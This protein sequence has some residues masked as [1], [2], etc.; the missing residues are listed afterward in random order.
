MKKSLNIIFS[1]LICFLFFSCDNLGLNYFAF[2]NGTDGN[3]NSNFSPENNNGMQ[4]VTINIVNSTGSEKAVGWPD[5]ESLKSTI[6]VYSLIATANGMPT[7][8]VDVNGANPVC[9]LFLN[10]DIEWTIGVNA[11]DDESKG[12][13]HLVMTGVQNFTPT[14]SNSSVTITVKPYQDKTTGGG[15]TG[16]I[17]LKIN[18]PA[19]TD[20]Y[21][22]NWYVGENHGN[23]ISVSSSGGD[24]NFSL[25]GITPGTN[26][27][28]M[29]ITDNATNRV[30]KKIFSVVIYSNVTSS[31]WIESGIAKDQIS[32]DAEDLRSILDGD[33]CFYVSG[34]G[35]SLG[36]ESNASS[37][38][39][40]NAYKFTTVQKAVNFIENIDQ[41]GNSEHTIYI[42]GVVSLVNGEETDGSMVC[43]GSTVSGSEKSPKITLK[44]YHNDNETDILNADGLAR[45]IKVNNTKVLLIKNIG[46]MNGICSETGA[47]VYCG[48]G[49]VDFENTCVSLCQSSNA[50]GAGGIFVSENSTVSF[51]GCTVSANIGLGYS[52][53][54]LKGKATLNGTNTIGYMNEPS[55]E[56]GIF[57]DVTNDSN[58]GKIFLDSTALPGSNGKICKIEITGSGEIS[59]QKIINAASG[60]NLTDTMCSWFEVAEPYYIDTGDNIGE[61]K[62]LGPDHSYFVNSSHTGSEIGTHTSPF[63][64]VQNAVNDIVLKNDGEEYTIYVMD[65]ISGSSGA[66]YGSNG[67]ALVNIDNSTGSNKLKLKICSDVSGAQRTISVDR[68]APVNENTMARVISVKGAVG[69]E[70]ELT[71]EDIKILNG[72]L[73][74]NNYGA[75]ILIS[76]YSTVTLGSNFEESANVSIKGSGIYCAGGIS[77]KLVIAD[78]YITVS[79]EIY[80]SD[81]SLI[82]QKTGGG[83]LSNK[84]NIDAEETGTLLGRQVLS[85]VDAT[86]NFN[87]FSKYVLLTKTYCIDSSGKITEA[88]TVTNCGGSLPSARKLTLS[89]K[90]ELN[91]I[92]TWA[93]NNTLANF[94]FVMTGDIDLEGSDTDQ[95]T[96]IGRNINYPFAGIFDGNGHTITGLYINSTSDYQGLFGYCKNIIKNICVKGEVKGANYAG[97]ICGY[98]DTIRINEPGVIEN[99][100]SYVD[101]SGSENVGGICGKVNFS[102][103]KNC[104]NLGKITG[105]GENTGG[106]S[107]YG[108]KSQISNCANLGEV[109]GEGTLGGI[110]GGGSQTSTIDYCYNAGPVTG[111]CISGIT[112]ATISN[113]YYL[114]GCGAGQT[115]ATS[116]P[117]PADIKTALDS[118]PYN[119]WD[120]SYVSGGNTYPVCVEIPASFMGTSVASCGDT[121]PSSGTYFL[122]TPAE[123]KKISEWTNSV[124]LSGCTF[125]MTQDIDLEG[126]VTNA[127]TPIGSSN[128]FSGTFDGKGYTVKGLYINSPDSNYQGLF[129]QVKSANIKNL[130]V[131]GEVTGQNNCGGIV[132]KI[133]QGPSGSYAIENCVSKVKVTGESFIGGIC[134]DHGFGEIRNCI[135][136]GEVT[137]TGFSGGTGGIAGTSGKNII[138]CANFG[139]V[140]GTSNVGGIVGNVSSSYSI[141]N[142]YNAGKISGNSAVGLISGDSNSNGSI[143]NNAYVDISGT[144]LSS[145]G[146]NTGNFTAATNYNISQVSVLKSSLNI[147]VGTNSTYNTWN[148]TVLVNSISFPVCVDVT[149]SISVPT[150][151]SSGSY[152]VGD[153]ILSD[154]TKVSG[155]LTDE[156]KTK[157]VGVVFTTTYN[158]V[159]GSNDDGN[160]VLMVGIHNSWEYGTGETLAWCK[161][162]NGLSVNFAT[163]DNDGSGNYDVISGAD[164]A[165]VTSGYYEVFEWAKNY[166]TTFTLSGDYASGWYVPA[167]NEMK[168]LFESISSVNP[169]L[170]AIEDGGINVDGLSGIYYTSCQYNDGLSDNRQIAYDFCFDISEL[171]DRNLG[172]DNKNIGHYVLVIRKVE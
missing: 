11:Y 89:T 129:G 37:L 31:K 81:G 132:G 79:D 100:V 103:I 51:N 32:F 119:N 156:Q 85:G 126:T 23:P 141:C 29:D 40:M 66:V 106:I 47:G 168:A 77:S 169:V 163:N 104:I 28:T 39:G 144:G 120:Y 15:I 145:Y 147:W 98:L 78:K 82:E 112:N 128:A 122:S 2:N 149:G 63:K 136:A 116:K 135:N 95:F 109:T 8:S 90:A 102:K 111:N 54:H 171:V 127:F 108:A 101:V 16:G 105:T 110:I 53:I 97:G 5:F 167:V 64:T 83:V 150:G 9:N 142:C 152:A 48:K 172:G 18:F 107:G 124:T 155:S 19:S 159:D 131:E 26:R 27:I 143:D 151:E 154:G 73:T 139:T 4:N 96:P 30:V 3:Q 24:A 50:S 162:G 61:V 166:G 44:G 160:T 46:I 13:S 17:N 75:G 86:Y 74:G 99:C 60:S 69:K 59:G 153:V 84:I 43:I 68:T 65:N 164:N 35:S 130:T 91:Q 125:V 38:L 52:N 36:E 22:V 133:V 70:V 7:Y 123:L 138:N 72:I 45:V 140:N 12:A 1:L 115:G 117:T 113:C 14:E 87:Y 41:D 20:G 94:I 157:A 71:L 33:Y 118:T 134:G 34:E 57:V 93:N 114:T 10:A 161:E 148:K 92:S 158:P 76:N 88:S 121:A 58:F 137:G 6:K 80:L 21:S 67:Y 49:N 55:S 42:D 62:K 146:N 170:S 165:G 25:T 56:T